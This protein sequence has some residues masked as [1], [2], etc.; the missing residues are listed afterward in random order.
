MFQLLYISLAIF[1]LFLCRKTDNWL[2]RSWAR[3]SRAAVVYWL[4]LCIVIERSLETSVFHQRVSSIEALHHCRLSSFQYCLPTTIVWYVT[5]GGGGRQS[6]LPPHLVHVNFL[7]SKVHFD[8]PWICSINIHSAASAV[9]SFLSD[10]QDLLQRT[11]VSG[12]ASK[13]L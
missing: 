6:P 2:H 7:C 4:Q 13:I 11:W 8:T 1:S 9:A 5:K 10:S 12:R 3:F